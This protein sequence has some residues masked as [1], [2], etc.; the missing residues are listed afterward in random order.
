MG[1]PSHPEPLIESL[2]VFFLTHETESARK[3]SE[4]GESKKEKKNAERDAARPL[5]ASHSSHA[6]RRT[7]VNRSVHATWPA[8]V[9]SFTA[10]SSHTRSPVQRRR[11][12]MG[13]YPH[14]RMLPIGKKKTKKNSGLSTNLRPKMNAQRC[15]HPRQQTT[16]SACPSPLRKN[17]K[18]GGTGLTHSRSTGHNTRE[19]AMLPTWSFVLRYDPQLICSRGRPGSA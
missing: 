16:R 14:L 6:T 1:R 7:I 15:S 11:T 10:R 13:L 9:G 8:E 4:G 17:R 12:G 2:W 19:L 3:L 18:A 5:P